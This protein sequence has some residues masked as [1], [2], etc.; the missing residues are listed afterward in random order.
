MYESEPVISEKRLLEIANNETDALAAAAVELTL[1][2]GRTDLCF[3]DGRPESVRNFQGTVGN[4]QASGEFAFVSIDGT[5][6]R[7]ATLTG[8]T[9]IVT[10]LIEITVPARERRAKITR[11]DP[12]AKTATLDENWPKGLLD[13]QAAEIGTEKRK[14]TY[15]LK[16]V[17]PA[18]GGS[19]L[20]FDKGMDF[21][22]S[23]IQN[24]DEAKGEVVCGL[25]FPTDDGAAFP[26]L[27]QD[28]VVSNGDLTRFWRGEYLGGTREDGFRFRLEGGVK[29]SDFP[30]NNLRVWEIGAGDTVR[31][32]THASLRRTGPGQWELQADTA[33]KIRW[34]GVPKLRI[35]ETGTAWRELSADKDGWITITENDLGTGTLKIEAT[36]K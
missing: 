30:G 9:Q 36:V 1:R 24:V 7:Q 26:G 18:Q 32:P 15:M 17:E 4:V 5:G 13:G 10:P 22:S 25:G 21:Y 16:G 3:A 20:H 29:P 2:D 6:L 12:F 23:L 27:S 28:V 8:G 31:I 14:T 35:S 34:T 19:L 11:I 33:L